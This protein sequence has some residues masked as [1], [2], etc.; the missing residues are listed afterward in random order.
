MT[1]SDNL[2]VKVIILTIHI[3]L[4]LTIPNSITYG[5]KVVK[6]LNKKRCIAM[7]NAVMFDAILFIRILAMIRQKND[8]VV[9]QSQE[10]LDQ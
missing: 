6:N 5:R 4:R 8:N 3:G 2:H 10:L 9:Y 1:Y 7:L